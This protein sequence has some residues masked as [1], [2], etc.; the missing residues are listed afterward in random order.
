LKGL[1]KILNRIAGS[2]CQSASPCC[3]EG[4][5]KILSIGERP[6]GPVRFQVGKEDLAFKVGDDP[7][8]SSRGE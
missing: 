6:K 4:F 8:H 3:L 1:V 7:W 2:I 5:G